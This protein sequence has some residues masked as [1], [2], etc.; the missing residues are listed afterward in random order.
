MKVKISHENNQYL[1]DVLLF[2]EVSCKKAVKILI[3]KYIEDYI[4]Y[5][6]APLKEGF[7]VKTSAGRF[8]V[9]RF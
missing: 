8:F 5:S 1:A 6:S 3:E 2:N 7:L 4:I 9:T